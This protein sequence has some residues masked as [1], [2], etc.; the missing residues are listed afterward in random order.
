MDSQQSS[1]K[2]GLEIRKCRYNLYIGYTRPEKTWKLASISWAQFSSKNYDIFDQKNASTN[3]IF[4]T[5][6]M[7]K[8]ISKAL[9]RNLESGFDHPSLFLMILLTNR[10][11]MSPIDTAQCTPIGSTILTS[12]QY[13]AHI[14]CVQPSPWTNLGLH[15][16]SSVLVRLSPTR[17]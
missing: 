15:N 2:L 13:L 7:N 9:H 3:C 10:H 5:K 17:K 11:T 12:G 1:L 4:F 16:N 14:W 8:T 6:R